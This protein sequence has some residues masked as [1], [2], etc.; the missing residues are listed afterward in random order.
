MR[1][2]VGMMMDATGTLTRKRRGKSKVWE[3][4]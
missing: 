2:R 4:I 1:G 3:W